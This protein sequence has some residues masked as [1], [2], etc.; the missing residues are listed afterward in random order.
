MG[1]APKESN[2]IDGP[3]D[4]AFLHIVE[5]ACELAMFRLFSSVRD[6]AIRQAL[7]Q[8]FSAAVDWCFSE[9]TLHKPH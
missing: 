8:G 6:E 2:L 3:W 5:Q 9:Q 1:E 4:K 7:A